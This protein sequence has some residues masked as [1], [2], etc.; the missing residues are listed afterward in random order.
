MQDIER[1]GLD[2]VHQHEAETGT[3]TLWFAA[4]LPVLFTTDLRQALQRRCDLAPSP[5]LRAAWAEVAGDSSSLLPALVAARHHR[6]SVRQ[7]AYRALAMVP[8]AFRFADPLLQ[9][10]VEECIREHFVDADHAAVLLLVARGDPDEKRRWAS[11]QLV[12][13]AG[14]TRALTEVLDAAA[15]CRPIPNTLLPQML[16]TSLDV[17]SALA[18]SAAALPFPGAEGT[19]DDWAQRDIF[20]LG[21]ELWPRLLQDRIAVHPLFQPFIDVEDRPGLPDAS[22]SL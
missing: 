17:A 2:F 4:F 21:T 10:A 16:R 20:M 19:P 9:S 12:R 13:Y 7:S 6:S 8:G 11:A 18:S 5:A 22:A 15:N 3:L 1:A 14:H